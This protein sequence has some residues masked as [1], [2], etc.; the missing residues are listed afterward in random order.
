[1]GS[2]ARD[3]QISKK[4][5]GAPAQSAGS[6]HIMLKHV[7]ITSLRELVLN[8]EA[9]CLIKCRAPNTNQNERVLNVEAKGDI[10]RQHVHNTNHSIKYAQNAAVLGDIRHGVLNLQEYLLTSM[11]RLKTTNNQILVTYLFAESVEISY[12]LIRVLAPS[13]KKKYALNVG[14]G[15]VNIEKGVANIKNILV[16]NVTESQDAIRRPAPN[17]GK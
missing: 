4:K 16:Q 5:V 7:A 2:I 13:I 15:K 10:I 8:A 1:M 14:A 17:T 11:K 9:S 3:A 6:E 12:R